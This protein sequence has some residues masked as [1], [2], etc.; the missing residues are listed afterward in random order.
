MENLLTKTLKLHNNKKLTLAFEFAV[1]ISETAK[2]MNV[3]LTKEIV[4]RAEKILLEEFNSRSAQEI[5][6]SMQGLALAVFE[7]N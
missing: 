1:I 2:S 3:E 5:A 6:N 7:P 4:E